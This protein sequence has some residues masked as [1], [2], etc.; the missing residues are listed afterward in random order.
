MLVFRMCECVC[1][2]IDGGRP[3]AL[4]THDANICVLANVCVDGLCL[5]EC[6]VASG[7]ERVV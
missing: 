1:V 3:E 6:G 2:G 4:R 5:A 7:R